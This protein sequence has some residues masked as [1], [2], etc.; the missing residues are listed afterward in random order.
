M[1]STLE[2]EANFKEVILIHLG[3]CWDDSYGI[4]LFMA[5]KYHF[6]YFLGMVNTPKIFLVPQKSLSL[7]ENT[8]PQIDLQQA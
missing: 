8:A 1:T 5:K 4:K 7:A 2:S 3:N 6:K